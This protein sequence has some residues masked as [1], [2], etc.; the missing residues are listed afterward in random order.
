[1]VQGS[2]DGQEVDIDVGLLE[3][4]RPG[5]LARLRLSASVSAPVS[6]SVSISQVSSILVCFAFLCLAFILRSYALLYL[7]SLDCFKSLVLLF[8][9]PFALPLFWAYVCFLINVS[10]FTPDAAFAFRSCFASARPV[11]SILL[12]TWAVRIPPAWAPR[13]KY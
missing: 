5:H 13:R 1:M 3:H 8:P 9:C 12:C 4:C 6:V 11:F 10:R 7:G 2:D